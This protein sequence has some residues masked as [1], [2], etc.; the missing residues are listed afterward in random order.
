MRCTTTARAVIH[1]NAKYAVWATSIM[2]METEIPIARG[3]A[4]KDTPKPE[5]LRPFWE[6]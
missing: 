4:L 1:L 6:V 5:E 2:K 3:T